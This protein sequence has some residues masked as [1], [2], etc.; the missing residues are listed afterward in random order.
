MRVDKKLEVVIPIELAQQFKIPTVL[1]YTPPVEKAATT[2]SVK[3]PIWIS[4]DL[5]DA[6]LVG[7]AAVKLLT[8]SP[9]DLNY[10]DIVSRQYVPVNS[11]R[12]SEI[13]L[14]CYSDITNMSPYE[15][16]EDVMVVLHFIPRYKRLRTFTDNDSIDSYKK[17][18]C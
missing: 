10:H 6:M 16:S 2:L 4:C 18:C 14:S 13:T 9:L 8:P 3:H 1:K 17:F 15:G 12:F 7:E 11:C 5:V